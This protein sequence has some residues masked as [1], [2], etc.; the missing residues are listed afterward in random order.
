MKKVAVLVVLSLIGFGAGRSEAKEPP[1]PVGFILVP[2]AAYAVYTIL[3]GVTV[4]GVYY[5]AQEAAPSLQGL[6]IRYPKISGQ[7]R[8]LSLYATTSERSIAIKSKL[9]AILAEYQ[10][11]KEEIEN[12]FAAR[13]KSATIQ[14]SLLTDFHA[15]VSNACAAYS[16]MSCGIAKSRKLLEDFSTVY[17][18]AF[19]ASSMKGTLAKDYTSSVPSLMRSGCEPQDVFEYFSDLGYEVRKPKGKIQ[20]TA[21]MSGRNVP[22]ELL[23]PKKSTTEIWDLYKNGE[24]VCNIHVNKINV[25]DGGFAWQFVLSNP[26]AGITFMDGHPKF[27]EA[28]MKFFSGDPSAKDPTGIQYNH[29]NCNDMMDGDPCQKLMEFYF[30]GTPF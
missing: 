29:D 20:S 17:A 13:G 28:M 8:N 11:L 22:L 23:T 24:Q 5:Y 14:R 12:A 3:T 30:N 10:N 25:S 18:K 2:E 7:A 15:S 16:E 27:M 6:S 4:A 19:D 21:S 9:T 1:A 26:Q